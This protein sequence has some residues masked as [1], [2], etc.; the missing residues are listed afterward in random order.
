[1]TPARLLATLV[2]AFVLACGSVPTDPGPRIVPPAGVIR[3]TVV[4]RGPH[5]CS[6]SGH[7]VGNAIVLVFDRRNPPPPNGLA[8]TPV[9]FGD[10]T[11]DRLFADEPRYPGND[12]T[13]C[14][15]EHGITDT[16]TKTGEFEIAPVAGGSYQIEAFFDYTGDFLPQFQFRNL[17]ERGDIAGGDVDPT[18]ALKPFN[19][20]NPDYEPS[21]LPVDVGIPE[22]SPTLAAGEPN[23]IPNYIIPA[24]GFVADNVTVSLGSDLAYTRPYFYP[25]AETVTVDPA[26]GAI[27]ESIVQSSDARAAAPVPGALENATDFDFMPVLTIPQDVAVLAPPSTMLPTQTAVDN[28]ESKFPRLRLEWGVPQKDGFGSLE[29][30]TA[31]DKSL[32]FRMQ[33]ESSSLPRAGGFVVWQGGTF[34]AATQLY[35]PQQIAEGGNVPF[36]WPLV[37]L[38]KLVDDYAP[39]ASG[40]Y[41]T[42]DPASLVIQGDPKAPLVVMQGITEVASA[43]P[44]KPDTLYGMA[45]RSFGGSLFDAK[46]GRPT[47]FQQDHLTVLVR[48]S[49]ICFDKLFDPV[50]SDK[51]GT[52]VTPYLTGDS[53]DVPAVPNRP[54]VPTDLLTNGDS[55]RRNVRSLVKNVVAG[56]LPI[57]RYAISVVYPDGQAWTV[58]NEAGACSGAEGTTDYR[59]LTC[60]LKRRPVLYSQGTRAVVEVVRA[61]DPSN[62]H[63]NARVGPVPSPCVS[64]D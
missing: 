28:F 31:V 54:I 10:V 16:V 5:P 52:L 18:E 59:H 7:I 14:P 20:G 2:L 29:L 23:V 34:D 1:M 42:L 6:I 15:L 64:H 26:S 36:L 47:I 60:T 57:G 35:A 63:P 9:N 27:A 61:Q 33:I 30:A 19:A 38:S 39:D 3:G 21:F 25:R 13:Y 53:S 44:A 48:P 51:R 56:C 50:E 41:H 49:V 55:A 8:R 43:D 11:G 37:V 22:A 4:Y 46:T 17:P 45:A 32:P 62:C 58:P 12:R 24:G 40:K